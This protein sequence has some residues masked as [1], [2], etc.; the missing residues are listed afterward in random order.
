MKL[1]P[2]WALEWFSNAAESS[3]KNWGALTQPISLGRGLIHHKTLKGRKGK[4][5]ME[6]ISQQPLP[7]SLKCFLL[8]LSFFLG[9]IKL[10]CSF[11]LLVQGGWQGPACGGTSPWG[12]GWAAAPF[13]LHLNF[14]SPAVPWWCSCYFG[15]SQFVCIWMCPGLQLCTRAWAWT[16]WHWKSKTEINTFFGLVLTF[17]SLLVLLCFLKVERSQCP[18]IQ[19]MWEQLSVA[20]GVSWEF[21]H[22]KQIA[23]LIPLVP[24]GRE[25]N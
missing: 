4:W 23:L 8:R 20:D 10:L 2:T 6:L 5:W 22:T 16:S 12:W 3:W 9:W 13:F 25:N 17:K 7:P 14:G 15:E 18:G 11:D 19:V 21:A 1:T 24:Q